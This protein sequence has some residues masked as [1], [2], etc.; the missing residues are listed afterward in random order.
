MFG[1][2]LVLVAV[3]MVEIE[4]GLTGKELGAIDFTSEV[5]IFEASA[6]NGGVENILLEVVENVIDVG[7]SGAFVDVTL[8]NFF[9]L[10]DQGFVVETSSVFCFLK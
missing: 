6:C 3:V 8:N 2:I 7:E 10:N 1:T 5:D 4:V 9:L